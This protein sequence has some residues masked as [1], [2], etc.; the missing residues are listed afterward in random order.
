MQDISELTAGGVHQGQILAGKYRVEHVIGT[1]GMGVVLCAQHI[2]LEQRVALKFLLP[3][4]L[5][6]P[7]TVARFALEARAAVKIRS[8]YVAQVFDVATL[9]NGMPYMVMEYLD[10]Q[11]LSTWLHENGVMP[12]EQAVELLLQACEAIADAHAQ[13]IIHRDLKPPNLFCVRRSDGLLAVKILDF[14]IS[15]IVAPDGS[16]QNAGITKTAVAFGSPLY[17]SPE[18]MLSARDVD[19]RTDI[20]GLG[21]ILYEM[22]AG[23]SPFTGETLPEVYARISSQPPIPLESYRP[24]VPSALAAVIMKCLEKDR[25]NR[26]PNVAELALA[27]VPFAPKRA[28][29]SAERVVRVVQA[30]GLT[31]E[32]MPSPPSSGVPAH[33]V[34]AG[35]GAAWGQVTQP[36]PTVGGKS[37]RRLAMALGASAVV[38]GIAYA[39]FGAK[40]PVPKDVPSAATDAVV[41]RAVS[42]TPSVEV[43][44]V[45]SNLPATVASSADTNA[46]PLASGVTA[47]ASVAPSKSSTTHDGSDDLQQTPRSAAN[48]AKPKAMGAAKPREPAATADYLKRQH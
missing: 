22:L 5:Q 24:E 13:G 34:Q 41:T 30:A 11:D 26:Y 4:A 19:A 33:L 45:P 38:C 32:A 16:A 40:R 15:K 46:L 14:G 43:P 37:L 12:I 3:E 20:W 9:D 44:P 23:A 28:K 1:G 31:D 35:T 21:A 27:L 10:G 2:H 39:M 8:E 48:S 6:H 36:A 17:M 25:T 42:A 7:D 18:Q 29:A 47:T